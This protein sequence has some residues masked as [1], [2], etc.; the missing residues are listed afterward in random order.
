MRILVTGSRNWPIAL[1]GAITS[2]LW[3]YAHTPP[4]PLVVTGHSGNV[5]LWAEEMAPLLGMT[6]ESHPADWSAHGRAA[7]PIR[8]QAMVD[9]GADICLA[10]ILDDSRGAT[11]CAERAEAAGIDVVYH[12]E[13]TGEGV[14]A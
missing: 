1:R 7:G 5:D 2:A 11:D 8:N 6:V 3:H 4:P 14:D 10:F 9:A 12:R 13:Y